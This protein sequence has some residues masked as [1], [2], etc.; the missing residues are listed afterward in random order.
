[1]PLIKRAQQITNPMAQAAMQSASAQVQPQ[2]AN[3]TEQL[4]HVAKVK[5]NVAKAAA[6]ETMSKAEW[7]SKD[8][9]ISRQGLFQA[10]LQ[11][12]GLLQLNTGNTLEDYLNL[13]EQA[14]ERGLQFV[15]KQ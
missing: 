11:S 3:T 15:N 4:A 9:R 6:S 5:Q 10:C 13:V 14:A 1:M 8:V 7:A 2:P 12:V